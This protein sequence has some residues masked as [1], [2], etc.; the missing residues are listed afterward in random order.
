MTGINT[1]QNYTVGRMSGLILCSSL[2]RSLPSLRALL[3]ALS[4]EVGRFT[5][6]TACTHSAAARRLAVFWTCMLWKEL[7]EG[8]FLSASAP[9]KGAGVLTSGDMFSC[10]APYQHR[11]AAFGAW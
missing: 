4:E 5:V 11:A 1:R 9:F 6:V 10:C 3:K 2:H 7:V 8:V